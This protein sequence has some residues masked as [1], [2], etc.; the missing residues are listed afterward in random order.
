MAMAATNIAQ[1][2]AL[3]TPAKPYLWE[4]IIPRVPAAVG[5]VAEALTFRAR[6]AAW[7]ARAV[8]EA[9]THFKGHKIKRP[10]KNSFEQTLNVTFEE[11][12]DGVVITALRNWF[13]AWMNEKTGV[14]QGESAVVVD[15]I[16]RILDHDE[17]V[18]LQGHMFGFFVQN[19]P[20][21]LLSYEAD[22]LLQI[23]VTFGFSYWDLE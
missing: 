21:V 10:S 15:A 9:F 7:P 13:N 4:F 17:S 6:V 11:G 19:M 16:V 3:T 8:T 20:A 12:M 5:A 18:V 22:G 1:V 2:R 23:P 14:G